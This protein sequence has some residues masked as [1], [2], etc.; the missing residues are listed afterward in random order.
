M[1]K[2]TPKIIFFKKK[3]ASA[4]FIFNFRT[5]LFSKLFGTTNM[6]FR[7]FF[8][9]NFFWETPYTNMRAVTLPLTPVNPAIVA[10]LRTAVVFHRNM[11]ETQ[12]KQN[13][14]NDSLRKMR[15][16]YVFC[17]FLRGPWGGQFWDFEKNFFWKVKNN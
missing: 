12:K 11:T 15:T 6:K 17:R 9:L 5:F 16:F 8:K 4:Y 13:C 10:K 14:G 7:Y 2:T 1:L 3:V